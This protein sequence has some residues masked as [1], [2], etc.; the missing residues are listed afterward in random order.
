MIQCPKCG[1]NISSTVKTCPECGFALGEIDSNSPQEEQRKEEAP[2]ARIAPRKKHSPFIIATVTVVGLLIGTIYYFDYKNERE[3]EARAYAMLEGCTNPEF[4]QD[5]IIRFPHSD[6]IEEVKE[7][8]K[9]VFAQNNEWNMILQSGNRDMIENFAKLHPTSPYAR[10]CLDIVDSID[11]EAA[12]ADRTIS[13]I[14]RYLEQHPSGRY[15]DLA[16]DLQNKIRRQA[17]VDSAS[18]AAMDTIRKDSTITY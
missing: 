15:I 6:Y 12:S 8:Y 17:M 2:Q 7:R 16:Q 10:I 9:E 11:W 18:V 4:Y 3:R 13:A 14:D 5:F 1:H